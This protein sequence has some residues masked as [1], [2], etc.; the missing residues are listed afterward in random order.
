MR[1]KS[2]VFALCAVLL[3]LTYSA[4]AQQAKKIPRIG[5]LSASSPVALSDR[6][7]AFRQGLRELGYVEG[8]NV[9]I[10]YRYAEGKLDRLHELTAELVRLKVEVIVT[11]APSSTRSAQQATSTIPIVMAGIGGD[12]VE[13]GFVT[14]LARPGANITG[15]SA[16]NPELSGKQLQLLTEIIPKL[17]R[18]AVLGTSTLPRYAEGMQAIKLAAEP[19]K[20]QLQPLDVRGPAQIEIVFNEARKSR[21]DAVLVQASPVLEAHRTKIASFALK[22]KLPTMSWAREFVEA[23][24]LMSYGTNIPDLYRRAAIYVDKILK[25]VKPAELPVEQP[26]KFELVINLKTAKQ[27]GLTIPPNVLARADKVIK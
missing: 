27:I 19:F 22:A 13:A 7:E 14:S 9:V 23:G 1:K 11:A 5:F 8:K 10:E 24:G 12:P 6:L 20:I 2:F 17:S 15:L 18:V 25:G 4:S 21:S 3:A 26:T 16:L